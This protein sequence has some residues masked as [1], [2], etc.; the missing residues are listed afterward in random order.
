MNLLE[1]VVCPKTKIT[2]SSR[3]ESEIHNLGFVWGIWFKG[4]QYTIS[5]KKNLCCNSGSPCCC[6]LVAACPCELWSWKKNYS[7]RSGLQPSRL[8]V[9]ATCG[10]YQSDSLVKEITFCLLG[11]VEQISI[12]INC[13]TPWNTDQLQLLLKIGIWVMGSRY[14]TWCVL[15][16]ASHAA[17]KRCV[18][19]PNFYCLYPLDT[20][21]SDPLD[22][23]SA[24]GSM[25]FS[26]SCTG[27][28]SRSEVWF[29]FYTAWEEEQYAEH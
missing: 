28:N 2:Q 23:K 17:H 8:A 13:H 14:S 5:A 19:F 25:F 15:P 3:T 1:S 7:E 16:V 9:L 27:K 10:S 4:F 21:Q 20:H 24:I 26:C 18:L 6:L 22:M 11:H 12:F 29:F